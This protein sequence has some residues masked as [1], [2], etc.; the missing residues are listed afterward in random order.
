MCREA[1]FTKGVKVLGSI[2]NLPFI[3]PENKLDE[4]AVTL[5]LQDYDRLEEIVNLL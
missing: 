5:A 4:I 1:R 3:L 2:D